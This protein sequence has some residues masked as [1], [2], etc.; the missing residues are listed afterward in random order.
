MR[1]SLVTPVFSDISTRSP[2]KWDVEYTWRGDFNTVY[3][4]RN[5]K[6]WIGNARVVIAAG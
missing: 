4:R 5:A 2:Q 3:S 6:T 1:S